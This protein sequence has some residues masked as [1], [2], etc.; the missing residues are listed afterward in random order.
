MLL[1][2]IEVSALLLACAA[3]I[4][5]LGGVISTV[6][7]IRKGKREERDKAHEECIERLR[8]V[9]AEAEGLARELHDIKMGRVD[10]E[11]KRE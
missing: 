11:G 10:E 8:S 6:W 9:R 1:A 3:F 4:S 2:K 5:A 7:S